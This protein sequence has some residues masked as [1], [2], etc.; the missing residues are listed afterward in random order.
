[1]LAIGPAA[2]AKT[3]LPALPKT[4]NGL[5]V[6]PENIAAALQ[7]RTGQQYLQQVQLYSLRGPNQEL[8]ATL[9]VG[10]F[11]NGLDTSTT[12]FQTAVATEVGGSVTATIRAKGRVVYVTEYN[13]L[14]VLLWFSG[15]DMFVLSESQTYNQPKTLLRT[16]LDALP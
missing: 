12:A 15:P 3:G 9:Q 7:E 8:N 1:M 2:D 14:V 13:N 6:T 16:A 4:L 10:R 5:A 11:I